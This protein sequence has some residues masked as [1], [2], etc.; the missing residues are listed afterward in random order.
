MKRFFMV[1]EVTREGAATH[2]RPR[3]PRLR[4]IG[5]TGDVR[6]IAR[7]AAGPSKTPRREEK[8]HG[9]RA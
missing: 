6:G 1:G 3:A 4:A 9:A 5:I 2:V 8:I 7:R